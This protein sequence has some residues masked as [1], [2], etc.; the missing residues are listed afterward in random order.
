MRGGEGAPESLAL[1]LYVLLRALELSER[2]SNARLSLVRHGARF[3]TLT[4][5]SYG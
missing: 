1:P 2:G 4:A 5:D 3:V